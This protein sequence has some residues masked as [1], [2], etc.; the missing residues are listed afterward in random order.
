MKN[1]ILSKRSLLFL[2]IFSL[3]Q[4]VANNLVHA[5]T[6]EKM[7]IIHAPDWMVGSYFAVM[8]FGAFLYLPF[9]GKL[10]DKIGRKR[11]FLIATIVYAFS[12]TMFLVDN[13]PYTIHIWR[14]LSGSGGVQFSMLVLMISDYCE[15]KHLKQVMIFYTLMV[16]IGDGI[17]KFIGGQIGNGHFQYAFMLQIA[18]Q[19]LIFVLAIVFYKN[20]QQFKVESKVIEEKSNNKT[21]FFLKPS[22]SLFIFT[23]IVL[24]NYYCKTTFNNSITLFGQK[25]LHFSPALIGDYMLLLS[26][27]MIIS[28]LVIS[29][30]INK[31]LDLHFSMFINLFIGA[32]IWLL[33]YFVKQWQFDISI[34]LIYLCTNVIFESTINTFV[35]TKTSSEEKGLVMGIVS[36]FRFLG[37]MIGASVSGFL[38]VISPKLPFLIPAIILFIAAFMFIKQYSLSEKKY[39]KKNKI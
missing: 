36:S 4:A 20:K 8:S 18:L 30:I 24:F 35:L 31:W 12:Q 27:V 34:V 13:N 17:G 14:F 25:N 5:V 2:I 1:R 33:V 16:N 6:V 26:G 21:S 29:P 32:I 38:Y 19:I 37:N 28:L 9:S 15:P 3:L 22:N 10:S 39:S 23:I 7:I 11:I